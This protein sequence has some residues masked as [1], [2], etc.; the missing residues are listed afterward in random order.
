MF[1][2]L[3]GAWS[4]GTPLMAAPDEPAHAIHAAAVVRGE[5]SGTEKMQQLTVANVDTTWAVQQVKVPSWY[6]LLNG[7]TDCIPHHAAT[8]CESALRVKPAPTGTT[9]TTTSAGRYNPLYYIAVGWPSLFVNGPVGVYLMR[10]ISA[11][12]A[13]MLLASALVTAAES[14]RPALAQLS[15]LAAATPMVL[16]LN[17]VVNPNGLEN[18]AALLCWTATLA[19][20]MDPRPD[21]LRR[22]LARIAIPA[23][24]LLEIRPLGLLWIAGIAFFG[25]VAAEG[26]AVRAVLRERASW[27]WTGGIGLA[28]VT[29][30]IWTRM[31]PDHSTIKASSSLAFAPAAK[32][33][34][35]STGDYLQQMIGNFGWLDVSAPFLSIAFWIGGVLL[36]VLLA[37]TCARWRDILSLACLGTTIV[38]LPIFAQG[39]E[40]HSVGMIWQG[41]YLLPYAVGLPILATAVIVR[42]SPGAGLLRP[43]LF[44]LLGSML[45]A[46][47][48]FAF[49]WTLRNYTVGEDGSLLMMSAHWSPP[50]TWMLW[51][52]V[53]GLGCLATLWLLLAHCGERVSTTDDGAADTPGG[54][55]AFG[56]KLITA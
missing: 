15:V 26:G 46:A 53:S 21:L 41:R 18:S 52:C 35:L 50:G 48:F 13:A 23:I 1:F 42:R 28:L 27:W 22:R 36:L 32:H 54:A 43:R 47:Q 40:A 8:E 56:D 45:A 44:L 49:V 25:L 2:A 11:A 17:G 37:M 16:F 9:L 4:I 7:Y 39:L 31:H 3:G 34:F 14:R 10:L 55:S 33:T 38:L 5:F 29:A 24:I 6:G 20:L 12:L 19:V 30:E 51:V